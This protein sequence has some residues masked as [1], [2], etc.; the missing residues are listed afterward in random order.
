MVRD[1]KEELLEYAYSKTVCQ[2]RPECC[3]PRDIKMV[4][5]DA[6][7]TMWHIEPYAIASNISGKMTLVDPDT[8]VVEETGYHYGHAYET[9]KTPKKAPPRKKKKRAWQR[10]FE[11]ELPEWMKDLPNPDD[12]LDQELAAIEEELIEN[13]AAQGG[14]T[15]SEGNDEVILDDVGGWPDFQKIHVDA[16]IKKYG[17][18]V[19]WVTDVTPEGSVVIDCEGDIY[20]LTKEGQLIGSPDNAPPEPKPVPAP[21]PKPYTRKLTIKLLPTFRETIKQLN[22]RGI[23]SAIISL[24]TPGTVKRIVEAFGMKDDFIEIQD[25]WENKGKVFDKIAY[26]QEVCP[27]NAMFVDNTNSHVLDVAKKCG[28][29]LQ[30]GKGKDVET[31]I[32]IMRFIK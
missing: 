26:R 4:M 22:D 2:Q 16:L 28:L 21:A 30:I 20:L 13:V 27:C 31:P 15:S 7:D 1:A 14:E 17:K 9:V 18:R 10:G 11:E 12:E 29:A 3:A 6:D 32:E 8:V 5:W 24:N 25:T 19:C 23:P